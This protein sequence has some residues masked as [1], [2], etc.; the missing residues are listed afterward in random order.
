MPG[1]FILDTRSGASNPITLEV[2]YGYLERQSQRKV[3]RR[4]QTGLLSTYHW[5]QHHQ[6]TIPLDFVSS[7]DASQ[8]NEWW[9][10]N[11]QLE[12]T[13]NTSDAA[14]TIV[15]H[16]MNTTSPLDTIVKPYRDRL[17]GRLLIEGVNE[18]GK[19]LHPFILDH[20]TWG[21]LDQDYNSL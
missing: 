12:I 14:S 6:F 16:L 8:I 21:R 19:I 2:G 15:C 5:T 17:Q 13:L 7:A 1:D 18:G 11:A 9:R 4:T 10:T 20:P 3:H